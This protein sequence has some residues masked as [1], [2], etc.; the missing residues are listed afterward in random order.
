MAN[1]RKPDYTLHAKIR[2][3][4][5]RSGELG[6]GWKNK[7]GS[8]T[9]TICPGAVVDYNLNEKATIMLFPKKESDDQK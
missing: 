4:N 8:I 2:F 9:I 1:T 7:D 3:S 5:R 6:A